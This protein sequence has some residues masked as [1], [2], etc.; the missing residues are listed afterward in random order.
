[1]V[2]GSHRDYRKRDPGPAEVALVVEVSRSSL[3][4]ARSLALTYGG[5]QIP[6]YWIVNVIDRQIEVYANPVNGVYPPPVIVPELGFVELVSDGQVVAQIPA[7]ELLGS[8]CARPRPPRASHPFKHRR[9]PSRNGSRSFPPPRR[10]W[11]SSTWIVIQSPEHTLE[12]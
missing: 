8:D 7:A 12:S 6:A 9:S 10:F 5:G 2:R 4:A 11:R 3:A 1:M